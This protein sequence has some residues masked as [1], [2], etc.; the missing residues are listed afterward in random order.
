MTAFVRLLVQHSQNSC[1]AAPESTVS[2]SEAGQ[3]LGQCK[4]L[5]APKGKHAL[6]PTT[7]SSG[8]QLNRAQAYDLSDIRDLAFSVWEKAPPAMQKAWVG[9]SIETLKQG[10]AVQRATKASLNLRDNI[11]LNS[12]SMP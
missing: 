6:F 2:F 4:L 10:Y 9:T 3:G 5:A 1:E 8:T 11:R 7:I 12:E